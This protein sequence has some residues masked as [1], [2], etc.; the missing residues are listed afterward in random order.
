MDKEAFFKFNDAVIEKVDVP[1][2]GEFNKEIYVRNMSGKARDAFDIGIV[3]TKD[4]SEDDSKD[5]KKKKDNYSYMYNLRARLAI[6]CCCDKEGK[7]HFDDSDLERLG[8]MS[9]A[10]L[11]PIFDVGKRL[12][13][14]GAEEINEMEKTLE[15]NPS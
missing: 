14:I 7:F 6:A 15:A 12:N 4:D 10:A 2:W 3:N 11:D 5:E 9:S 8:D 1:E 13:K